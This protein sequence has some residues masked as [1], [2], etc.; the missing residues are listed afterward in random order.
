MRYLR[1]IAFATLTGLVTITIYLIVS[2]FITDHVPLGVGL[3]RLLQWD[4]SNAY[5]DAAYRGGWG[6]AAAGMAMDV[7]VTVV[8]AAVFVYAYANFTL[9]RRR[10]MLLGFLLGIA[11]MIVMTYAVVPLGHARQPSTAFLAIANI[12][13][14]HALFFGVPVMWV[15]RATA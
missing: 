8:W 5:G 13:I 9:V 4:A 10:S 15:V 11:V 2:R 6:M 7:A 14:A 12:A 3:E 1:A